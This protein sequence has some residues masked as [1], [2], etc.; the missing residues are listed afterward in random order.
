MLL[1]YYT[2]LIFNIFSYNIDNDKQGNVWAY[3]SYNLKV[4]TVTEN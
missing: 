4:K 1:A 3:T 2:P